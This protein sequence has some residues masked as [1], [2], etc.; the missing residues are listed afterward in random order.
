MVEKSLLPGLSQGLAVGLELLVFLWSNK[1]AFQLNELEWGSV[2][3]RCPVEL[4]G[5]WETKQRQYKQL[6]NN[7]VPKHIAPMM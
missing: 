6:E 4:Q 7:Y 1:S 3:I 5:I 2:N